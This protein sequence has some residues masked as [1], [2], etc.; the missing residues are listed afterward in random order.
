MPNIIK[1]AKMTKIKKIAENDQNDKNAKNHKNLLK[2]PE[3]SKNQPKFLQS[4]KMTIITENGK[5]TKN[6]KK[7]FKKMQKNHQK[8]M[9]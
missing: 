5:I 8:C 4:P 6:E 1:N 2:I 3:K 7:T 9:R